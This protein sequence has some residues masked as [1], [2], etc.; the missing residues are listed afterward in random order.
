MPVFVLTIRRGSTDRIPRRSGRERPSGTSPGRHMRTKRG[1]A[2]VPTA[3]QNHNP[4]RHRA[5]RDTNETVRP[6]GGKSN[7]SLRMPRMVTTS[8]HLGSVQRR[9]YH[10]PWNRTTA[11]WAVVRVFVH[12]SPRL[13][14]VVDWRC[15]G[16]V[17]APS[18]RVFRIA[19]AGQ[20]SARKARRLRALDPPSALRRRQLPERADA[21]T[22]IEAWRVC[23]SVVGK[24]SR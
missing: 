20:G 15:R 5:P 4:A 17:R 6:R 16:G 19:W 13:K 2:R 12:D 3:D 11:P 10:A 23:A 1:V 21:K 7:R 24:P 18:D 22:A 14:A 9:R 8:R